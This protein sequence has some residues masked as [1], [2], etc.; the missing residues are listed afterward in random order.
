MR[1]IVLFTVAICSTGCSQERESAEAA[2]AQPVI[3]TAF[4]LRCAPPK[5][6]EIPE[7]AQKGF[8]VSV[9]RSANRFSFSWDSQRLPIKTITDELIVLADERGDEG[10]DNNPYERKITFDLA[11]GILKFRDRY[12]GYI[13]VHQNFSANCKIVN[14]A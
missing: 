8:D 6:S 7:A 12:D 11:S 5:G 3:P 9:D 1:H 13:P 14:N 10:P 2:K 4:T